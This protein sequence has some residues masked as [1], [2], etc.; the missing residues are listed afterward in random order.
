MKLILEE[1]ELEIQQQ[2]G[3]TGSWCRNMGEWMV[4]LKIYFHRFQ[5]FIT[6]VALFRITASSKDGTRI[7][8]KISW[9]RS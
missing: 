3:V 7:L 8:A 4:L 9:R 2:S 5:R 1:T 6:Y